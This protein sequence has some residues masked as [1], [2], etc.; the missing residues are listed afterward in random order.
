MYD[1]HEGKQQKVLSDQGK[2]RLNSFIRFQQRKPNAKRRKK[3]SD[4]YKVRQKE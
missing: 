2:V 4:V 3:T 1:A